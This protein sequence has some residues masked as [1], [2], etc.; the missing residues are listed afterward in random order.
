M[1]H[2]INEFF[3]PLYNKLAKPY[4][5]TFEAEPGYAVFSFDR[6]FVNFPSDAWEN[7]MIVS[8]GLLPLNASGKGLINGITVAEVY[9]WHLD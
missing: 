4:L 8:T 5:Q 2:F 6:Q 9:G 1:D 7:Q 3:E